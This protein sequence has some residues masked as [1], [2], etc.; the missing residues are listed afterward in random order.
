MADKKV[1][2][3]LPKARLDLLERQEEKILGMLREERKRAQKKFP[4]IFGLIATFGVAAIFAGFN[5][6][7]S[8]YEF[9]DKNPVTL[10]L[11]GL[12]VLIISGAA[13][14]KLN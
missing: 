13:Y 1:T 8:S 2:N 10:V 6:M 5:R 9:L 11:V 3:K 12:V 4:L 14:K 7:I